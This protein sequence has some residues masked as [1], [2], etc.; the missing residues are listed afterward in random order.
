MVMKLALLASPFSLAAALVTRPD[1][2][3]TIHAETEED[4]ACK[5]E[6]SEVGNATVRVPWTSIRRIDDDV[7]AFYC[8]FTGNAGSPHPFERDADRVRFALINNADVVRDGQ[9]QFIVRT[10]RDQTIE[11]R[12]AVIRLAPRGQ[13]S[14]RVEVCQAFTDPGERVVGV[15]VRSY[16]D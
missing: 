12:R 8:V 14:C 1:M 9:F 4:R 13:L 2:P 6:G 3:P 7:E 15:E 5:V 11:L 10:S 16:T